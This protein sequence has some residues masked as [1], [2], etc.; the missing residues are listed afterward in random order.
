M[1][2]VPLENNSRKFATWSLFP[3]KKIDRSYITVVGVAVSYIIPNELLCFQAWNVPTFKSFVCVCVY[4]SI[5][6]TTLNKAMDETNCIVKSLCQFLIRIICRQVI[7]FA[8]HKCCQ[9]LSIL[10]Y[11]FINHFKRLLLLL[12]QD[13]LISLRMCFLCNRC[14]CSINTYYDFHKKY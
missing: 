2:L 8:D 14:N 1:L 3:Y 10:Q 12:H 11:L 4:S 7:L 9:C 5:I 13:V 6:M